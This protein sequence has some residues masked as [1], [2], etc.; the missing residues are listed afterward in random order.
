MIAIS[1]SLLG[2]V[3]KYLEH[4][5][6]SDNQATNCRNVIQASTAAKLAQ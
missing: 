1:R 5:K 2:T 4:I 6:H 3:G